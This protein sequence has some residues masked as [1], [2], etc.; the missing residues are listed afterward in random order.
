MVAWRPRGDAT[1]VFARLDAKQEAEEGIRDV[2]KPQG[3]PAASVRVSE[4]AGGVE[5]WSQVSG[6]LAGGR[7]SGL[8][9]LPG[10]EIRRDLIPRIDAGFAASALV[11]YAACTGDYS[12]GPSAGFTT[13]ENVWVSVGYNFAGFRDTDSEG[14][15][16]GRDG[17]FIKVR[18]KCDRH[19]AGDLLNKISPNRVW[20]GMP[21]RRQPGCSASRAVLRRLRSPMP[22]AAE[23]PKYSKY[24]IILLPPTAE[25]SVKHEMKITRN[26]SSR[27]ELTRFPFVSQRPTVRMPPMPA[28][29][30]R[31]RGRT[32]HSGRALSNRRC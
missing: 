27:V 15:E 6:D 16:Y 9:Q 12:F 26:I 28:R 21:P 20:G 3:N 5:P 23:P 10:A 24:T 18:A 2:P 31:R 29:K 25:D 13:A 17:A 19:T 32:L 22:K 14:A 8:T 7:T 1:L 4:R 30:R 11:G